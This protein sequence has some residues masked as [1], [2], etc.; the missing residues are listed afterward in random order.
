M[1]SSSKSPTQADDSRPSH[2]G[3]MTPANPCIIPRYSVVAPY[4]LAAP[5]IVYSSSSASS[6]VAR[7]ACRCTTELAD[8]ASDPVG[9][10]AESTSVEL[11][12]TG[13][14]TGVAGAGSGEAWPF[15]FFLT[16]SPLAPALA[17]CLAA[18]FSF[19]ACFFALMSS[20]V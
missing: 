9:R 13:T 5:F 20:G 3:A 8:T 7:G 4:L 10:G 19:L 6:T 1:K 15:L 16:A 18:F 14:G 12:W 2:I 11:S 17:A